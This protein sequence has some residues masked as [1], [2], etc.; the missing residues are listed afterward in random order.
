MQ[1]PEGVPESKL[2][3]HRFLCDPLRGRV[4]VFYIPGVV[5]AALLNPALISEIPAGMMSMWADN[6]NRWN[7]M[8][9]FNRKDH[10]E[11][12]E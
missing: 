2:H 4:S 3:T 6:L 7:E 5:V 8:K 1:H 10:K 11:L 12:K 9:N